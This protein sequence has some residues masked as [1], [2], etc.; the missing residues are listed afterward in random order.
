MPGEIIGLLLFFL[1][2]AIPL[3]LSGEIGLLIFFLLLAIPS[4]LLWRAKST[5]AASL[6]VVLTIAI[7]ADINMGMPVLTFAI[8]IGG[9]IYG[10]FRRKMVLKMFNPAPTDKRFLR[11]FFWGVLSLSLFLMVAFPQFTDAVGRTQTS[12][13]LGGIKQSVLPKM[14]ENKSNHLPLN[15]GEF[16]IPS[17]QVSL[18]E[19]TESGRIIV[20]GGK[21]GQLI[22]VTP[23]FSVEGSR[24]CIGGPRKAMPHACRPEFTMSRPVDK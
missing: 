5:A 1:L 4:T 12:R 23:S 9:L 14:E 21:E 3:I 10:I 13:W 11:G 22:V 16:D 15:R 8:L 17:P 2:L 6:V 18:F 7:W 19:M 24:W 20:S